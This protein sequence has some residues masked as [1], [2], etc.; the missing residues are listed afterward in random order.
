M[1][2]YAPW[3]PAN[4]RPQI[5][6]R[7]IRAQKDLETRVV[8]TFYYFHLFIK[9]ELNRELPNKINYTI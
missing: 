2:A 3:P 1:L 4:N 5:E 8:S 9:I 6:P 7:K